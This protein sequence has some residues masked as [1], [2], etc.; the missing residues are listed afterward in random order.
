M[1]LGGGGEVEVGTFT[2]WEG[3]DGVHSCA[4]ACMSVHVSLQTDV[5][6]N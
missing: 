5:F 3:E 1:D 6:L 4:C 2:D